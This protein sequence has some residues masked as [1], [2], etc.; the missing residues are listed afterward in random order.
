LDNDMFGIFLMGPFRLAL[1]EMAQSP[2]I[3]PQLEQAKKLDQTLSAVKVLGNFNNDKLLQIILLGE[4]DASGESLEDLARNALDMG[5]AF[6]PLFKMQMQQAMQKDVP[7]QVNE[8]LFKVTD[9]ILK[10]DGITVTREGKEV[11]VTLNKP[12][13]L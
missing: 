7:P 11:T 9:Q 12:K 8:K 1:T 2:N 6:Y 10:K 13:Q 4:N 5:K 3:P